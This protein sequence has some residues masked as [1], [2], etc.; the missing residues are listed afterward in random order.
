MK[1]AEA[2]LSRTENVGS[3][4]R[5]QISNT[6]KHGNTSDQTATQVVRKDFLQ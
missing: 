6:I 1:E 4:A 2:S 5:L 3:R